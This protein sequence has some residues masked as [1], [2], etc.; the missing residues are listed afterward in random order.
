MTNRGQAY[1]ETAIFLPLFLLILFGII[2]I[3]QSSVMNERLQFA[4]RY[5][6]LIS[7][8]A[9]PYS[10]WSLYSLYEDT[11]YPGSTQATRTCYTPAP[12]VLV[13]ASPFPGPQSAPFWQPSS[14]GTPAC[15]PG[16]FTDAQISDEPPVFNMMTSSIGAQAAVPS[17]LNLVPPTTTLTAQETF[18]GAP[19]FVLMFTCYSQLGQS[20][21]N[22]LGNQTAGGVSSAVAPAALPSLATGSTL[23]INC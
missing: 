18:L 8:T 13:N 20:I 21:S 2:W 1:I 9:S 10:A 19:D 22:S 11:L 17:Y 5:S 23:P 6:G 4:V 14:V 16:H 12:G 3:V 7:N 15:K